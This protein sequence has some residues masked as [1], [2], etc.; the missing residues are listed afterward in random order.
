MYRAYLSVGKDILKKHPKRWTPEDYE[1]AISFLAYE[2]YLAK[3]Q[4]EKT[5]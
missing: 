2:A 4:A 1:D 3:R 5:H